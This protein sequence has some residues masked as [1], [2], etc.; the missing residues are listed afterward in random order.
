MALFDQFDAWKTSDFEAFEQPKWRSNRFNVP[1]GQV[2]DRLKSL[3]EQALGRS[4]ADWSALELWTSRPEPN[5]FNNHEVKDQWAL[6]V[7]PES[8]RERI[9]VVQ[10]AVTAT[11][12]QLHHAHLGV[13]IDAAGVRG[14]LRVPR[15]AI[16]D[17][18]GWRTQTELLTMLAGVEPLHLELDGQRAAP[19]ALQAAAA[20]PAPREVSIVWAQSTDE[21]LAGGGGLDDL[22][23]WLSAA[24]PV[25]QAILVAAPATAAAAP[26]V[27]P[28]V[29]EPAAPS[30]VAAVAP[31]AAATQPE[32][33]P[34]QRYRPPPVERKERP[35]PQGAAAAERLVPPAL[36]AA[37]ERELREEEAR[38]L[39]AEEARLR[40]QDELRRREAAWQERQQYPRHAQPHG[41]RQG[42]GQGPMP[43]QPPQPAPGPAARTD[44]GPYGGRP[45]SQHNEPGSQRWS[46]GGQQS[47][48]HVGQRGA[49]H[50]G[51]AR[52]DARPD[53]RSDPRRDAQQPRPTDGGPSRGRPYEVRDAAP[54]PAVT[55]LGPGATVAL[56]SGLFSGKTGTVSALHG[57][58]AQVMLGLLSVRVPVASL[59]LQT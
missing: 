47:G 12:P 34:W 45:A 8:E 30:P 20:D 26:P 54:A 13:Q 31:M 23:M 41:G 44:R 49:A 24:L 15:E 9:E 10:G 58:Q 3:L 50:G 52:W 16:W 48:E 17:Q 51:R 53:A 22:A 35:A 56:T 18:P 38:R 36:R 42:Q 27:S 21:A 4:G 11:R 29:S 25:L 57:D 37:L 33:R 40:A 7:R 46:Q 32:A 2:R 28:A 59:R 39:A 55:T 14:W 5:F 1:R 43:G 6:L 19:E